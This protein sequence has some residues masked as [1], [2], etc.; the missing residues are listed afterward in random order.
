MAPANKYLNPRFMFD[1][2]KYYIALQRDTFKTT[3][4]L[5]YKKVAAVKESMKPYHRNMS[6][7]LKLEFDRILP[8]LNV[9]TYR[10]FKKLIEK[11]NKTI[12]VSPNV[13]T[14]TLIARGDLDELV[15]QSAVDYLLQHF[16]NCQTICFEDIGHGMLY[17]NRDN[18]IIPKLVEFL[19]DGE[20]VPEVPYR[21][22]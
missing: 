9:H 1:A 5:M 2:M 22:I 15:P 17:T 12:D 13:T 20:V 19:S 3:D 16:D 6:A 8:N 11:I 4:G 21:D 18:L 7:C 14:P 10:V